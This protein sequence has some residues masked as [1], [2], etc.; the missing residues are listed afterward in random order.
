MVDYFNDQFV[1]KINRKNDENVF[2]WFDLLFEACHFF[3][4]IK[5]TDNIRNFRK[6]NNFVQLMTFIVLYDWSNGNICTVAS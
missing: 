1:N 4:I 3:A 5:Y 6:I 2:I